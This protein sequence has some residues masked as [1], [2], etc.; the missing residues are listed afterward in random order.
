MTARP[1]NKTTTTT[2]TTTTTNEQG[3]TYAAKETRPEAGA[4]AEAEEAS[5]RR[6]HVF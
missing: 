1:D 2:T 3:G 5:Q 6:V 4:E